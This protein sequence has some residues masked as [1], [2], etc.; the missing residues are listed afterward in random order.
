MS[1]RSLRLVLFALVI[2]A[3]GCMAA[4]SQA[5]PIVIQPVTATATSSFPGRTPDHTIDGSG[6]SSALPTGS[7]LPVVWPTHS[8]LPDPDMWHSNNVVPVSVTYDLGT[9]YDRL[10]GFHV[11][12]FNENSGNPNFF[13]LRG[14][15]DVTVSFSTTGVGGPFINPITFTGANE[16]IKADGTSTWGGETKLFGAFQSAQ[17]IKFDGLT[18]WG[19]NG[20]FYTGLSEVRFFTGIEPAPEPTSWMLLALGSLGLVRHTRQ[21]S[22]QKVAASANAQLFA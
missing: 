3:T 8:N 4:A 6:L 7:A 16:F 1:F 10:E 14:F 11:W 9:I 15:R 20:E 2:T 17:W 12:N 18:R 19:V 13:T 5:A 21:R 22:K